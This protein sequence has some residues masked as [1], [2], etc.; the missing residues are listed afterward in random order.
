LTVA[1]FAA[2]ARLRSGF[3]GLRA[4]L[5]FRAGFTVFFAELDFLA[6][7]VLAAA[8]FAG[9]LDAFAAFDLFFAISLVPPRGTDTIRALNRKETR[10]SSRKAGTVPENAFRMVTSR[11]KGGALF[12]SDSHAN[13]AQNRENSMIYS[14]DGKQE[15]KLCALHNS[16]AVRK[17]K[18]NRR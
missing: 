6:G 13:I 16:L 17:P 1:T 7:L 14:V 10:R 12:F 3:A 2:A 18:E 15:S 9:A 4:T 11:G 8:D 5:A